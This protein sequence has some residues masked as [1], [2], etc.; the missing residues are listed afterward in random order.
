MHCICRTIN[1][2]CVKKIIEVTPLDNTVHAI[3][4][5]SLKKEAYLNRDLSWKITNS[6]EHLTKQK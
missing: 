6:W 3:P 2:K 4:F 5:N 1:T